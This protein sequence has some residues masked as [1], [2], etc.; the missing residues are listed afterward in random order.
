MRCNCLSMPLIPALNTTLPIY[1]QLAVTNGVQVKNHIYILSYTAHI[2]KY[3][4][5]FVVLGLVVII[6][7]VT[8]MIP[9]L[10]PIASIALWQSYDDYHTNEEVL[11]N[12]RATN[13]KQTQESRTHMHNSWDVLYPMQGSFWPL[14]QPMTKLQCNLVCHCLSLYPEWSLPMYCCS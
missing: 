5:F 14:A 2:T 6:L 13:H 1:G 4:N 8:Q 7:S 3:A 12:I 9:R 10:V 11:K